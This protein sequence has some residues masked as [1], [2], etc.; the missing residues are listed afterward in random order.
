[1]TNNITCSVLYYPGQDVKSGYF[2]GH[3]DLEFEGTVYS[4]LGCGF[5]GEVAFDKRIQKAQRGGLPFEQFSLNLT[6]KQSKR[7][8]EI[9]RSVRKPNQG[10]VKNTMLLSAG[11]RRVRI[12]KSAV[13]NTMI[14]GGYSCM[15][16]VSNMLEKASI[17]RIPKIVKLSPLLS[18]V[19]LRSLKFLGDKQIK[20]IT[21]YG[22]SFSSLRNFFNV[23]C[24]RVGEI[25]LMLLLSGEAL[26]VS[27]ILIK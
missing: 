12:I 24:C 22:K 5:Q 2:A 3:A 10:W 6:S 4:F 14:P 25:A 8:R 27:Y 23:N 9:L 13:K 11:E 18:S 21:H 16:C 20:E 1:M 17:I 19:Y 7:L 26:A 15:D